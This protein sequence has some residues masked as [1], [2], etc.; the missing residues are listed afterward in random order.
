MKEGV[1]YVNDLHNDKPYMPSLARALP[2]TLQLWLGLP[3]LNDY[4]L[5]I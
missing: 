5:Y 1:R 3:A 2:Q 4:T